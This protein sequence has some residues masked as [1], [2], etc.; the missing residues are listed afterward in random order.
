MAALNALGGFSQSA[1]FAGFRDYLDSWVEQTSVC[2]FF[3]MNQEHSI[4][5]SPLKERNHPP[6]SDFRLFTY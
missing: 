5:R 4:Q 6:F 3:T 2:E 1:E